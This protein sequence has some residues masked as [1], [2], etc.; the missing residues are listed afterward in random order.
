MAAAF[1]ILAASRSCRNIYCLYQPYQPGKT[2]K[3]TTRSVI[4][5]QAFLK[6]IQVY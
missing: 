5:F 1:N 3:S 4:I 6:T 2:I